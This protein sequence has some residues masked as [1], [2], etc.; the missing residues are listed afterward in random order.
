MDRTVAVVLLVIAVVAPL[1]ARWRTH[2]FFAPPALAASAWCG[3]L[4]LY[5]LHLLPYSALRPD[6]LGLLLGAIAV[7]VVTSTLGLRLARSRP[8]V[9]DETTRR[10]S[11]VRPSVWVV[12]YAGLGLAGA[13]WYIRE[14]VVRLGWRGFLDGAMVRHLLAT[15]QIP[16]AFLFLEFFCL[17]APLLALALRL[18]GERLSRLA[19]GLA[20]ACGGVTLLSTDRTQPFVLFLSALFMVAAK[21]GPSLPAWRAAAAGGAV[22]ASLLAVFF[23][24]A[25]WTGKTSETFGLR[26]QLPAAAPGSIQAHVRAA[27]LHGGIAYYYVTSPYPALDRV[28][29]A[30]PPPTRGLQMVYP[31]ARL[32]QRLGVS[33][34][35]VPPAIPPFV[36]VLPLSWPPP[37]PTNVY[38]FLYYPLQD[39]G[40]VCA[41][42]YAGL[43]GLIAG[44]VYGRAR[45][46]GSSAGWLVAAGQVSTG[47]V[48]SFFVNKFNNT[49]SWYILSGTLLP[50]AVHAVRQRL[51]MWTA[52][53]AA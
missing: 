22:L 37:P 15:Y 44:F 52:A 7:L 31:V 39:F 43:I 1:L 40:P 12:V 45:A 32:L 2:D 3:T 21:R 36:E 47:L 19:I 41:L 24:V 28:I 10:T 42:A 33:S 48:L 27:L 35:P 17:I 46:P 49:A 20:L 9:P 6:T 4:G 8:A 5:G 18:S 11:V 53:R 13:A 30:P 29:A 51:H 14:V 34:L 38:T 26:L 50:F 25:V 16:S 23:V